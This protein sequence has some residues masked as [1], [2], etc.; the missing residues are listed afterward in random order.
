[1]LRTLT[2]AVFAAAASLASPADARTW[3]DPSG[4]YTLDAT[5]V[6]FDEDRVVLSRES[7]SKLGSVERAELSTADREYLESKAAADDTERGRAKQVWRLASGLQAPGR[8][9]DYV[10]REVTIERRR[11]KVLVNGQP[12]SKLPPIYQRIVPMLVD[13]HER[14]QVSDERGLKDWL[15]S[16]KGEP[17]AYTVDGVVMEL[18]DG[19]E[20]GVPFF[21]FDS[22]DAAVLRA[23]W[24]DWLA[25]NDR[26][27]E[28]D[29]HGLELRSLAEAYRKDAAQRDR[30]ARL[31]L[32]MQAIEAGVTSLWEVTLYP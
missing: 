30:V 19:R 13:H 29:D 20:F 27:D 6:A 10:R 16:R 9:V 26:Y 28:Q 31:Q 32:G 7:D 25:A 21:L 4:S 11:G 22:A 24:E 2:V 1:M 15:I 17:A 5:L 14:N 3:S 18:E 8:V 23:G 12:F